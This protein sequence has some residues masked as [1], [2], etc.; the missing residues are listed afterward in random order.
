MLADRPWLL[1][2]AAKINGSD[3]VT[4]DGELDPM[5]SMVLDIF[6]QKEK[7]G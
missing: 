3:C 4:S 1:K 6:G 7:T 2:K 5:K